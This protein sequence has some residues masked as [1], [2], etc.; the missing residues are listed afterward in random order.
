M[1]RPKWIPIVYAL[2]Y[3]PL[4][5]AFY[6]AVSDPTSQIP[7][8]IVTSVTAAHFCLGGLRILCAS[9]RSAVI[10]DHFNS[11]AAKTSDILILLGLSLGIIAIANVELENKISSSVVVAL[12]GNTFCVYN[13]LIKQ[14]DKSSSTGQSFL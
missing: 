13:N 3:G 9:D 6:R 1:N 14:P 10:N 12:I 5:Y 7:G 11:L 4:F 2:Y 8:I